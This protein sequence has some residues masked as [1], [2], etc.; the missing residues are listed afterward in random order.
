MKGRRERELERER[1]R[2]IERLS[3]YPCLER[4]DR[5]EITGVL[6]SDEIKY[7]ADEYD[8]IDPFNE[9]NLEPASYNVSVGDQYAVGG[10]VKKLKDEIDVIEILPFE[11]SVIKTKETFNLPRFIIGRWNIRVTWA[12]KGLLWVGG[13]QVDPGY[14]G[15]LF[16][17]IY[18]LSNKTVTLKL[19]NK[20]ATIDFVK[21]TL[22]NEDQCK[23]FPSPPDRRVI[24][25][26][27]DPDKLKSGLITI[28]KKRIEE[29]DKKT[30]KEL[31]DIDERVDCR[32]GEID[33]EVKK[34]GTRLDTSIGVVF[35]A[36]A[37]IVASLSIIVTSAQQ[38]LLY[39]HPVWIYLNTAMSIS[40]LILAFF[41]FSKTGWLSK[42]DII[43][44]IVIVA[45][46]III[47][48]VIQGILWL[49]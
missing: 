4:D 18:N 45:T 30:D 3:N 7:Y 13:P 37:I 21:T 36:I 26:D 6:L 39:P 2:E 15:H 43:Y 47:A 44:V 28:A 14:V 19:G 23:K 5:R 9:E 10:K 16:C 31:K 12:Y 33:D 17:P 27:Y 29:I 41:I 40:A 32:F 24:F 8:M 20:I 49:K 11:V 22:F 35:T 1:E 34:F 48:F 42:K 46:V 25:E 38:V